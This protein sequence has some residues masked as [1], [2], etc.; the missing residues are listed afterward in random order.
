MS[1]H[2]RWTKIKHKKAAQGAAKGKLFTKLIKELTVAARMGGGDPAGNARLRAAIDAA[3]EANMP[4]ENITRGIKKGT[5]ELEGVSYEEA[6]YEGYGPGG[7]AMMVECLTDNK[8]RTAGDV[9]TTFSKGGG[10]LAAEGAVAWNFERMGV[11]EVRPG[12]TEERVTEAAIEGGAEDVIDHGPDG[13][14]VRTRP[15]DLHAV[16]QALEERKMALGQRRVDYLPKES[17][18]VTDPEKGK[19]LLELIGALEDLDDV[20]HVWANY[21]MDDALLEQLA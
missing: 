1:G 9:R 16:A 15:A 20:Q 3:K 8:N 18:K 6:V 12:P 7:V 11:I 19:T 2:N 10:N 14:E 21:E 13:F 4:S 5:G 17:V